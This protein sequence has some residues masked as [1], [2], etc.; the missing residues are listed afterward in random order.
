MNDQK[1]SSLLWTPFWPFLL[2][3]VTNIALLKGGVNLFVALPIGL[4]WAIACLTKA[5]Q[6]TDVALSAITV[7]AFALPILWI[8]FGSMFVSH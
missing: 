4:L 6:K 3:I 1:T 5:K 8:S 2:A 7:T